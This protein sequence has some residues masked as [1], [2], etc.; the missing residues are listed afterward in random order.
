MAAACAVLLLASAQAFAGL[1]PGTGPTLPIPVKAPSVP[2]P[3]KPPALTVPVKP[4]PVTVPVKPPPVTVPVKPP[5]VT[6]PVKPPPVTVPVK[7]PPVTVPVKPPPV[8]VPVKPPPVKAPPVGVPVKAPP[9]KGAPGKTVPVSVPV[10]KS[11]TPGKAPTAGSGGGRPSGGSTAPSGQATGQAPGGSK[12]PAGKPSGGASG[13]R[14]HAPSSPSGSTGPAAT[15]S[16]GA[17]AAGNGTSGYGTSGYGS[18][19]LT[20][21]GPEASPGHP[22]TPKQARV[23]QARALAVKRL[24][25]GLHGCLSALPER[26]RLVLELRSGID[27]PRELQPRAVAVYLHVP[28]G[29]VS[30]LETTALRR[31]RQSALANACGGSPQTVSAVLSSSYFGAL[32]GEVGPGAGG[33]EAAIYRQSPAAPGSQ[34]R[35]SAAG[36]TSFLGIAMPVSAANPV[37]W[38]VVSLAGLA[39]TGFL[40]AEGLGT[41]PRYRLW[42]QRWIVNPVGA[43]RS[44]KSRR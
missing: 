12:A 27:V 19:P 21:Y 39:L 6:V 14:G 36:A 9:V 20:G 18:S 7:P 38:I 29:Q 41:G 17:P 28:V 25:A 23:A 10:S 15:G 3:V 4:P 16:A 44:R 32:G 34:P 11:Q 42:R 2:V 13:A 31:L 1:L 24:V 40:F 33:V 43:L 35:A 26:L 8:T 5:P 37:L 22:L 30:L